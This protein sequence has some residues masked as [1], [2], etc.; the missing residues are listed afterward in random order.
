M[1]GPLLEVRDLTKR[2]RVRRGVFGHCDLVAAE[3]V[4]LTVEA[5]DTL[6]LV[7]ESGSGKSTV[8]RCLLRLEEPTSGRVFLDGR[9]TIGLAAAE[10]QRL[11]PRMQMVYQE[12]LDSLNPRHR[13]GELVAEPL[14]LHGLVPKREARARVI[15]L[16]TLAGLGEEHV[17]RYAH[18]LSG[19]QQQRVGI[20]RAL[21]TSPDLVVLDEP[22]SALDVSVEAQILNLLRDLQAQLGLAYLLISHDLAVVALL[23]SRV[24]V[25][26]VGQIV[27][28]GPTREVLADGFHP[29]TRALVSATPV[30]HPRQ[31]KRRITLEGEPTSPIDPPRHCRLVGRCPYARPVCSEITAELVEVRPGRSTRCVRFQQEHRDGSWAPMPATTTANPNGTETSHAA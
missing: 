7:G 24:A 1:S 12:P 29:Y 8:G 5:G 9:E 28:L 10:I 2:Y 18:E 17:D 26:Y 21:A 15:E 22:T 23:A 20:A 19:G 11:R 6:A 4:S 30:D 25:M 16:F 13:V 14:W 31:A 27:E 3:D